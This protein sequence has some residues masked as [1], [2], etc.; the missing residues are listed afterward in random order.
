[1]SKSLDVL[2]TVPE[3]AQFLKADEPK[4]LGLIARGELLALE[5][6]P[7]EYRVT[8]ADLRRFV[9]VRR[10]DFRPPMAVGS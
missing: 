4:I 7:G 1:M 2:F 6:A 10:A 5:L 9:N 8:A 3:V